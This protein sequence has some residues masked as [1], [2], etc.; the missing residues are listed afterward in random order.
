MNKRASK[1]LIYGFLFGTVGM[2]ILAGLALIFQPVEIITDFLFAPGRYLA[3]QF[4]GPEGSNT[5]V[6]ILTLLNGVVYALIF[7]LVYKACKIVKKDKI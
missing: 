5:E 3:A 6:L 1:S 4:A 7:A 2:F